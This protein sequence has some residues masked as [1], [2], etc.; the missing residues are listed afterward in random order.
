[1]KYSIELARI[2]IFV[3]L[4]LI[5]SLV[6]G[7]EKLTL[8][9]A[10]SRALVNNHQIRAAK[11]QV[12]ESEADIGVAH[13]GFMPQV[14]FTDTFQETNNPSQSFFFKL[15]E[16]EFDINNIDF[17]HPGTNTDFESKLTVTQPL[18]TGGKLS[19]NLEVAKKELAI[20]KTQKNKTEE[21]I[22]YQ[23]TQAYYNVLVAKQFI[24]VT[25][26]AVKDAKE[27][28]R[29][30]QAHYEEGHGI[31]SDM[32]RSQVYLTQ[33]EENQIK[34]DTQL[35][36]AKSG[37]A[38]IL[39]ES[40]ETPIDAEGDL[41]YSVQSVDLSQAIQA[42]LEN[43]KD[44]QELNLRKEQLAHQKKA[45]QADYFPSVNL[46]GSY[47]LNSSETPFGSDANSWYG[48]VVLS[49][50]L[51]DGF[52]RKNKLIST[53]A[54]QGKLDEFMETTKK[55]IMFQITQSVLKLE[56]ANKR[57]E[58][59]Q[60]SVEQAEE[61]LRLTEVR[62][63]NGLATITDITDAQTALTQARVNSIQAIAEYEVGLVTVDYD[64]GQ[65][66]KK[67][68]KERKD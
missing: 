19:A 5:A 65:L 22:T 18:F 25:D 60:N 36:I 33:M 39:G 49:Y 53:E 29:I 56:E 10:V 24:K 58:L 32:L 51:F 17:N 47:Q 15:N 8:E 37:F 7:E 31:K 48:A 62:Y 11:Q 43:R 9:Q 23:V 45:T 28:Y 66:V 50:P 12:K 42:G 14:T 3:M 26:L 35:E 46:V 13:S 16:R 64:T 38:L 40:P 68:S 54:A 6:F 4:I 44:V 20:S 52:A 41:T 57:V 21:E 2:I 63:E 27:H 59:T 67:F 55:N 1:M 61:T 34:A 30:A